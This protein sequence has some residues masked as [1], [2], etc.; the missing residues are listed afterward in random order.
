MITN[1]GQTIIGKYLLGYAP[2]YASHIA[3][4]CG[5]KP[6][7]STD[8]VANTAEKK[9][10]DFEMFRV[11]ISS[12]GFVTEI[13]NGQPVSKIVLTAELPSEER[14]EISELGLYSAE[15]NETAGDSDSKMIL[16]FSDNESWKFYNGTTLGE[17]TA[18]SSNLGGVSATDIIQST[19]KAIITSS[20]N[21][22]FYKDSRTARYERGRYFN[23]V[24]MLRGDSADLSYAGGRLS[25]N[26]GSLY[27]EKTISNINLK[28]NTLDDEL[29]LAICL[30]NKDGTSNIQPD[31]VRILLEFSIDG[32]ENKSARV[33][34]V[35]QNGTGSGEIDFSANRYHIINTSLDSVY[36]TTDFNWNSVNTVRV[37]TSILD[38]N[39]DVSSNFY[40]LLDGLRLENLSAENALYGLTGY[41]VIQNATGKTIV[42]ESNTNNYVEFRFAIGAA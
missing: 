30:V 35:L 31:S 19:D 24:I 11:P 7:K 18:I 38:S 42:K 32:D 12:K 5:S 40:L 33:E 15:F 14:Y 22:I 2:A 8:S 29:R 16:S 1:T 17:P 27:L 23:S 3:V 37:Y 4:G 20:D 21:G 13:V 28:N 34:A 41:S 9:S 26:D 36:T 6:Y 39:E 25:V 10:L